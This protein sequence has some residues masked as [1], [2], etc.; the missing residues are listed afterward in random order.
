M[1]LA[2]GLTASTLPDPGAWMW[3]SIY[4]LIALLAPLLYLVW[5]VQRGKVTDLDVQRR[6]QRMRPL[7]VTVACLGVA[8]LTLVVGLAPDSLIVLAAALWL[9]GLAI[10]IVTSCWKISVHVTA[11]AGAA[12]V[13]AGLFGTL[14][15]L[16]FGV[17]LIAWSRVRLRRH[18][19]L[20]TAAGALLGR[21]IFWAAT[22][23]MRAG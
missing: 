17:P 3:A 18:T 7:V 8:W 12:T 13:I 20:Q 14:W 6:K 11:A 23:L 16:F 19:L 2:I 1:A 10:L 22:L 4:V 9:Q 5:L 15:P 21:V